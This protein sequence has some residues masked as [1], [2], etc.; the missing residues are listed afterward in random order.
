M[1]NKSQS[2]MAK[3]F[4]KP[5]TS[6]SGRKPQV[7]AVAGP[8]KIQTDFERVFKPFALGKDKVLAPQ[9]W[10]QAQKKHV[11]R[12]A[13]AQTS[14]REVIVL[15]SEDES[16]VVMTEHQATEKDLESMTSRGMFDVPT[17]ISW[18]NAWVTERLQNSL[19]K[20]SVCPSLLP[21]CRHRNPPGFKIYHSNSVRDFM[22]QLSEA[23]L[24]GNDDIVREL[25]RE[26]NDRETFPAKAFCLHTD[27][28]PG[29]FGT[30]TRSS[31][32]IGPRRPLGQDTL[33][34]DY[35][36]DS[37][38]EW[39]EEAMGEDVV[40]DGE[41]E[42]GDDDDRDSDMESWLVDDDEE[43]DLAEGTQGTSPPPVF[44]LPPLPKRK[45]EDSERKS[46]KKR[47]V[48]I[49]L[50]PFAKGPVW[51]STIGQSDYEPF[52]PYAIR[53]FNGECL[54]QF[55]ATLLTISIDTPFP[56]D[57]F[58]FVSSCLEDYKTHQRNVQA[59]NKSEDGIFVVPALPPRLVSSTSSSTSADLSSQTAVVGSAP[60]RA[61]MMTKSLF[62][63]AH[64]TVLLN[65]I[66]QLQASSITALV[67]AVYQELREHKIKKIA[68]ET[69][70]K[71]VGEKCKDT[72]V[73]VVKPALMVCII[74][75]SVI[76][77]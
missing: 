60:K 56:I 53:F 24:S 31:R 4:S 40:E 47:K 49:P 5:K 38:E 3:F 66:N 58:N 50:M 19:S 28:R 32:I 54:N 12:T 17:F 9:N 62:P 48:V 22:T 75:T 36:H 8:S 77:T 45:A 74:N 71:E 42:D 18:S 10:F 33:V 44:D 7:N 61:P 64:V 35:G 13:V 76:L 25:L 70:I 1:H 41:D 37:G 29:Y 15:E 6:I 67:E 39:E 30:W 69:K 11:R 23:E 73:W 63:E 55:Q 16:D 46:T 14:N 2:L 51:E 59:N 43:I 21:S 26:L 65:K 72:K 20:L 57:P 52:N 27:R 34:F 68:I